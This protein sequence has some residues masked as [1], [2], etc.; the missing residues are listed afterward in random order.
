[1]F[2]RTGVTEDGRCLLLVDTAQTRT[3]NIISKIS[4]DRSVYVEAT[5]RPVTDVVVFTGNREKKR[6]A[7]RRA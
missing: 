5:T 7:R 2:T 4:K 6:T 1:M 3:L